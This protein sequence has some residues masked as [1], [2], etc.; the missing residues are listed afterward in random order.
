MTQSFPRTGSVITASDR[1]RLS[2]E[3]ATVNQPLTAQ[4]QENIRSNALKSFTNPQKGMADPKP[5]FRMRGIESLEN[6]PADQI[7][8]EQAASAESAG[9]ANAGGGSEDIAPSAVVSLERPIHFLTATGE[10]VVIQAGAYKIESVLDVNFALTKEGQ[11]SILLQGLPGTHTE[12]I[13]QP[14]ALLIQGER[15]DLWHLVLLMPEG[16][17]LDA[18]GSASGVR[19]RGNLDI[20]PADSKKFGAAA[21]VMKP[22][23]GQAV[24]PSMSIG[25]N[26][27]V[28]AELQRI[29]AEQAQAQAQAKAEMEPAALL[30]RIKVLEWI[31]ACMYVEGY[32]TTYGPAF[33]PPKV[34]PTQAADVRWNGMKCP[35]K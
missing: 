33:P 17:R 9:A 1:T 5:T 28:T 26:P 20:V 7:P 35:G 11:P 8:P 29:A 30:A 3:Y 27:N 2:A 4:R 23:A 19:P 6:S 12:T 21:A 31:L 25:T 24:S 32:G 14:T 10:D 13:S 34:Y 15:E 18:L 22:G 16:R